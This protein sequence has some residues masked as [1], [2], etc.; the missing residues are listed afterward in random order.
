MKAFGFG[1]RMRMTGPDGKVNHAE[2]DVA[3]D[4]VVMMGSPG[5]DYQ[6]PQR[7][8]H[9]GALV[10]IYVD[11]VDGHFAR[12]KGAGATVLQEPADQFFGDR[13][14][15][16]ADPEGQQWNFAQHVRDVSPEEMA[17]QPHG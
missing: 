13:T 1:E 10:Y 16:V 6:S 5:S 17:Q 3:G 4:S 8:G 14:Y 12:A 7:H 11:D 2:V 9:V 15:V